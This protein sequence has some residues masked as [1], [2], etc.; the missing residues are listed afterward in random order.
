MAQEKYRDAFELDFH[1]KFTTFSYE[2]SEGKIHRIVVL[3]DEYILIFATK[4]MQNNTISTSS[5]EA[6]IV[7]VFSLSEGK[8]IRYLNDIIGEGIKSFSVFPNGNIAI[9]NYPDDA[10]HIWNPLT[11]ER[12]SIDSSRARGPQKNVK[13]NEDMAFKNILPN[14]M[15]V[16]PDNK[17]AIYSNKEIKLWNIEKVE[18]DCVIDEG[19]SSIS[20]IYAYGNDKILGVG[21]NSGMIYIWRTAYKGVD[22][23]DVKEYTREAFDIEDIIELGNEEL[24]IKVKGRCGIYNFSLSER[25]KNVFPVPGNGKLVSLHLLKSGLLLVHQAPGFSLVTRPFPPSAE[26]ALGKVGAFTSSSDY[27]SYSIPC[28]PNLH[29][30]DIETRKIQESR[31]L[32]ED[33]ASVSV[34]PNQS[35]IG[36]SDNKIIIMDHQAHQ[37]IN[38]FPPHESSNKNDDYFRSQYNNQR[39]VIENL[40]QELLRKKEDLEIS[41]AKYQR[42]V[43]YRKILKG[44]YEAQEQELVETKEEIKA[45]YEE[46]NDIGK[47][48]NEVKE[49]LEVL[50]KEKLEK[51]KSDF[52]QAGTY[53]AKGITAF[54]TKKYDNAITFFQKAKDK[55]KEAMRDDG[56]D[57]SAR[58]KASNRI[59]K[60]KNPHGA[61]SPTRL[62]T[63]ST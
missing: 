24:C 27:S 19:T 21:V 46:K 41:E 44:K 43:K 56:M 39:K 55:Y 26:R 35:L 16:L 52:D 6:C 25:Q 18:L 12:V 58:A 59:V 29:F 36:V 8:I 2:M 37:A 28:P 48:L 50:Q 3:S 1:H 10:V 42:S 30:I 22:I 62:A 32:D 47:E 33:I 38:T 13:I 60:T 34:L 20:K 9:M 45:L 49:E 63:L 61:Y 57:N 54:Y 53:Y 40:K 5:G 17:L 15:A 4:K 14:L 11:G 31:K 7:G 23:I 51:W